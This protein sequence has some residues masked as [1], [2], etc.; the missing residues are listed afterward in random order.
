LIYVGVQYKL[1]EK[2]K[3]PSFGVGGKKF[4]CDSCNEKFKT[5]AEL[6]DHKVRQ[7]ARKEQTSG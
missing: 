3:F 4:K 2:M 7:H 1:V 6:E 5:E